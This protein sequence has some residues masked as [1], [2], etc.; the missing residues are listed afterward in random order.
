[1]ID[2]KIEPDPV[3]RARYD[4]LYQ[5]WRELYPATRDQMHRLGAWAK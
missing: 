1:M 4:E 3:R 2:H 5:L